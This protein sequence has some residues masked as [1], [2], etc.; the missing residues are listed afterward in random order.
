MI[1]AARGVLSERMKHAV[2]GKMIGRAGKSVSGNMR[3]W[4]T[5]SWG[6]YV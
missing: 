3:E 4:E 5:Y 1:G 2:N 6:H